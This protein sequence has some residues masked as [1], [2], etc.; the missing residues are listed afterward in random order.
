MLAFA[1]RFVVTGHKPAQEAR[2]ASVRKYSAVSG[3]L[4]EMITKATLGPIPGIVIS[5]S[6]LAAEIR[7]TRAEP[8][9]LPR[10]PC[11]GAR[12]H[13]PRPS[14]VKSARPR[15]RIPAPLVT[16]LAGSA[17]RPVL[18]NHGQVRGHR[19]LDVPAV[20]GTRAIWPSPDP[21]SCGRV[22][23]WRAH[24]QALLARGGRGRSWARAMES[25]CL[26]SASGSRRR[27]LD[28]DGGFRAEQV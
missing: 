23:F 21:R 24:D 20:S 17:P 5:R 4:S 19:T 27:E 12:G 13:H 15:I 26:R 16:S 6:R 10:H 18:D 8:G 11:L 22:T 1:G 28:R 9:M 7:R 14:P 2:C 3:P 25:R